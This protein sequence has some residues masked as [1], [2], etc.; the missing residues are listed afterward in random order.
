MSF[1]FRQC[2]HED[3][4][5]LRNFS[6]RTFSETFAHVNAPDDMETYLDR[7]F[8]AEKLRTELLNP[9]SA[10]YFLYSDGELAGYLKINEAPAQTDIHDIKSLEIERIYV[11]K[12][13]QGKGLGGKL[14]DKAIRIAA[15]RK[16]AY[17][18]LGVWEKNE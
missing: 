6:Y 3:I 16:K 8:E 11:S 9:H 14:M 4:D 1:L 12:E 10:F 17:V 2:T 13:F 5:V 15:L 18:W 7:A